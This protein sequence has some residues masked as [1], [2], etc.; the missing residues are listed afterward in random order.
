VRPLPRLRVLASATIAGLPF[1]DLSV[2]LALGAAAV[3]SVTVQPGHVHGGVGAAIGV[4][5]LTLPVAWSRRAPLVAAAVVA[6]AALAN[7]LAFGSLPRC[8]TAL[9]AVFIIVFMVASRRDRGALILG[10]A[11]C[12]A[13]VVCQAFSDP[14][15]GREQVLLLLPILGLFYALGRIVRARIATVDSLRR[16]TDELRRQREQTAR[17]TVLADRARVSQDL[18]RALRD[19][20]AAIRV[21]AAAGREVLENDPS[22]AL[23][24]LV[25]IERDGREVLQQMREIVGSLD[26]TAPN[27]P[28]PTLAELP[29]L[30]ATA[31]TAHARLT[32]DGDV[33][34]LTAGL[35]LAG[36]RIA[37]HLMTA[38]E[39]A[40]GAT[41]DVRLRYSAESLE[42]H[43]S[44]PPSGR[45][46]LGAILA[47][48]RERASLHRGTLEDRSTDGICRA[49]ARLPLISGHA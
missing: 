20:I 43:V 5:A 18:D 49:M 32:I 6:L 12:A 29:S 39:D 23:D 21:T 3:F 24:V 45:A 35:E 37:E 25:S 31:T 30:L 33:R 44:G 8:G 2:A 16:R 27:E 26:Q 13:N 41:I 34:R 7:G 15:L 10:F 46:E 28:S 4:L 40:P 47:A 17:V 14:L 11:L 19:R 42:L 9:P 22:A 1:L 48:A 38:L 36:Y